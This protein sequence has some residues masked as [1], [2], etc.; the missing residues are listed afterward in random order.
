MSEAIER[1]TDLAAAAVADGGSRPTRVRYQI[2]ISACGL[3]VI[4][5]LHRVGFATVSAEFKI[6]LGLSDQNI[7]SLMAAFMIGYGVFEMPWGYLGDRFGVRH[8]VAG[9]IV[10]GSLMTACVALVAVLPRNFALLFGFLMV[11]RFLLGVFQAG[12]FPSISRIMADWLPTAER[13]KAQGAIWMSSRLGGF[14]APVVLIKLIA[15][16]GGWKLPWLLLAGLGLY[17]CMLFWP[18]FRNRPH[19]MAAVNQAERK[20][21]EAGQSGHVTH[22]HGD[23]P[24]LRMLRSRSVWSLLLMYAFLG[25][26]GNFYLTLLPNYLKHHRHLDSDVTSWLTALPFGFGVLA[27][28]TGG[29]LSDA[30]IRRWGTRWGR[31]VV[32]VAGLTLAG[33]AIVAVPWVES[34][35]FLGFLLVVAFFG[36]DLAMAPAWASAADIGER[37]TGVLAG[38]MNMMASFMAALEAF[39]LGRLMGRHDL[40]LPFILLAASYALGTIAWLGVD[41]RDTLRPIDQA[42]P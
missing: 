41:V 4:T 17:W 21:I 36:N 10:G 30:I 32:G 29:A 19:D 24:W 31:R 34:T 14:L 38:A 8:I 25:F 27:C 1:E 42:E 6:P 12:T 9:V 20:L 13:G 22:G 26:S 33:L 15:L 28:I 39:W 7:A 3:A 18:W 11:I 16:L 35:P 37:Y 2:L 5:Y 40:V 23:V